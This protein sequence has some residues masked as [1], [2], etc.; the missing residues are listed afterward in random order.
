MMT[1]ATKLC[2]L[3]E[4]TEDD[5]KRF[6]IDG[7]SI[8]VALVD[9]ECFAVDDTCTHANVSLSEGLIEDDCTLE[10]PKHGALFSLRTGEALTLPA[11][12]P[13]ATYPTE[14]RTG[15]VWVDVST[16]DTP[17]PGATT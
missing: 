5:V 3:D 14:I 12:K 15:E 1:N 6:D 9:G 7:K 11:L 10:C 13:V 2:N 4:L 17:S 8:A 16:G